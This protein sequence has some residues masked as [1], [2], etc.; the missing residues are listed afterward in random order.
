MCILTQSSNAKTIPKRVRSKRLSTTDLT[1]LTFPDE[2]APQLLAVT[3]ITPSDL[4]TLKARDPFMYYSIASVQNASLHLAD[5]D[6]SVAVDLVTK[7]ISNYSDMNFAQNASTK[8][9]VSR[10]QRISTECHPDLLM[11]DM[12][13]NDEV[14]ASFESLKL[15]SDD[16]DDLLYDFLLSLDEPSR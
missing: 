7:Q 14:M 10:K 4:A 2:A 16:A 11:R 8:R 3:D 5:V 13:R 6:E 9:T 15:D 1:V 12:L